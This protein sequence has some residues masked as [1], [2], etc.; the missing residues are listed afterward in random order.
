MRVRNSFAVATAVAVISLVA[1]L[2]QPVGAGTISISAPEA[3]TISVS[4]FL[5]PRDAIDDLDC[6]SR[7][8][9]TDDSVVASVDFGSLRLPQPATYTPATDNTGSFM[10]FLDLSF[11]ASPVAPIVTQVLFLSTG[12]LLDYAWTLSSK[13][14]SFG[15]STGGEKSDASAVAVRQPTIHPAPEPESLAYAVGAAAM[16]GVWQFGRRRR[17]PV[18]A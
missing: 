11:V 17:N 9:T 8:T 12:N 6:D 16:C 15:D 7:L 1:M 13:A 2:S 14:K 18:G 4:R 10:T 3:T 5:A